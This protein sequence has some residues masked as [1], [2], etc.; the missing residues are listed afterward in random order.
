M[1]NAVFPSVERP[2][3]R[4]K[5]RIKTPDWNFYTFF[6]NRR[7]FNT[8][9]EI[10]VCLD[11]VLTIE[12]MKEESL[13]FAKA[14][15]AY[16]IRKG[17]IVPIGLPPCNE[18]IVLFFA[19]NRMGAILS[20][21]KA[22]SLREMDQ[23]CK[24]YQS[25]LCIFGD[26]IEN[27]KVYIQD[28]SKENGVKAVDLS[29]FI[30]KGTMA[31]KKIDSGSKDD[32]AFICYT[33]G[34]TGEPKAIVLTNGN[35]MA[36]MT[37]IEKTCH[38]RL[39]PKG[40][41]LQV[42]P[43]NYPYGFLISV[44]YPMYVGK[45]SA[46]TP[47]LRLEEAADWVRRYKPTYIQAIPA[48]YK[49]LIKQLS[50][51]S[52]NLSFIMVEVS[53]GDTLELS[54]KK[55][56]KVC[57]RKHHSRALICDG[58]GNGEGGGCLTTS[59]TLGHINW[60]SVGKPLKGLNIKIID[61]GSGEELGYGKTGILCFS[62]PMIMKEY[63]NDPEATR[64]VLIKEDGEIWFHT[65]TYAHI[66]RKG[67]IYLD[68]RDRRFFITFDNSGSPYKVY[69]DHVQQVI[70]EAIPSIDCAVVK[71]EDSERSFIPVAFYTINDRSEPVNIAEYIEKCK[72][73]LQ[74]YEVPKV[75]IEVKTLP[76]NQAGKIDY[77]RLE[78]M[79]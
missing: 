70:G 18:A 20:F 51:S 75:W 32:A 50:H 48:F 9:K 37:A 57:N 24:K 71:K 13:Q 58:S 41:S 28:A 10:A 55:A 52:E 7:R 21:V 31:N 1:K 66:D 53:G 38:M 77:K 4:K 65:D 15:W 29:G 33:S 14:F 6:I 5:T 63:Y 35:L 67:F 12:R 3:D 23:Y 27:I 36:S 59:A 22:A 64:R 45:T 8:S 73:C 56:L 11:D 16:G 30:Q 60:E 72:R 76:L 69:C 25:K 19:L 79:V 43:F 2:W 61:P 26:S 78:E 47:G 34:S 62:G 17:D 74:E 44:I 39:G 49:E 40:K 42:V 46:L 54:A 68:G